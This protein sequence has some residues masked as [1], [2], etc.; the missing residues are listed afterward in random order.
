MK[1]QRL[2]FLIFTTI[3]VFAC[4]TD[5]PSPQ[6]L[7][8]SENTL[9]FSGN[10]GVWKLTV[11][12]NCEWKITGGD[13]WCTTDKMEGSKTA[14]ILIQVDTNDT[15]AERDTRFT[16]TCDQKEA[17]V[18]V[19]QDTSGNNYYYELPVIFHLFYADETDSLQNASGEFFTKMIDEC[20]RL[21]N[22]GTN[23][24]PM[25]LKLVAATEDPAGNPLAEPGIE[26]IL[27]TPAAVMSC[28]DFMA[29]SNTS[30][31]SFVWDLNKYINV[32]VYTFKEETTAGIS[33][34]PYTPRENSLPGLT[35]NN[36]YFS[37]MPSYTHCIS[38][39]NTYITEDDVYTTL[40]HELGHY[41]GLFHVLSE[42]E[43]NETDYC[44]DTPN[45]DRNAYTEWLST[46]TPPYNF[47]EVVKR[48]GCEGESFISTNVMDYFYS[49]QNRFT[50]N[51]YSRVRHVLENSPLIPGPKNIITTKVAREDIVP[52][53]RAIE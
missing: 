11:N 51:Q 45:Y 50:A 1:I 21:Y 35:A 41:L 44:E 25:N 48:N 53:A 7:K 4:V 8:I 36:H 3:V 15:K 32:F 13:T 26:R 2:I 30:F 43:C 31:N 42:Q 10:G 29:Q 33:H 37:N 6:V 9:R 20:N 28:E 27:K 38:I 39:N 5:H 40:A 14:E 47:Q 52:A 24:I 17:E 19:Y 23:S 49:Y 22:T 18:H 34:L 46:L 16:F 12:S